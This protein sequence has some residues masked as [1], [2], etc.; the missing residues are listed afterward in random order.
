MAVKTGF[1]TFE[2]SYF[3]F[4]NRE[5]FSKTAER[6]TIRCRI[7]FSTKWCI[8]VWLS[9][10]RTIY[11]LSY[12]FQLTATLESLHV[13]VSISFLRRTISYTEKT[14]TTKNELVLSL[15]STKKLLDKKLCNSVTKNVTALRLFF[16]FFTRTK[17]V[18]GKIFLLFEI[19]FNALQ[20]L[21]QEYFIWRTTSGE[22]Q[23]LR[24][25]TPSLGSF[26]VTALRNGKTSLEARDFNQKFSFLWHK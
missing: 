16:A 22:N 25:S 10:L 7:S 9:W 11:R 6:H 24:K 23:P 26:Y 20:N 5:S 3:G 18:T 1:W 12:S 14:Y 21:F 19:P 2:K 8:W 15:L 17:I 13:N 4:C